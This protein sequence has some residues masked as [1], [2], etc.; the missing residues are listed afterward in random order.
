MT[1][2]T[3]TV[4]CDW[5]FQVPWQFRVAA[6]YTLQLYSELIQNRTPFVC[7]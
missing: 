3:S 7:I 4:E 6:H 5:S 1:L 2:T